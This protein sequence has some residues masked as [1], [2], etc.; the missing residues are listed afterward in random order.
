MDWWWIGEQSEG[1]GSVGENAFHLIKEEP[2][3]TLTEI[4]LDTVAA[5]SNYIF[6]EIIIFSDKI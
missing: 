3:D 6:I 4:D 5:H 2:L 1:S